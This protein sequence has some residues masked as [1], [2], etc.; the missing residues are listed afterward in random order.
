M[1]SFNSI[2]TPFNSLSIQSPRTLTG[3]H[4]SEISLINY[5]FYLNR[6]S[7]RFDLSLIDLLYVSNFKGGNATINV[8]ESELNIKLKSYSRLLRLIDEK[9]GKQSL[10]M[11]NQ[12]ETKSLVNLIMEMVSLTF[13]KETNIDGFKSSYL[14]ALLHSFFPML[15]P[16]LD[17]RLLINMG[18]VQ[19]S[20]LLSTKQV[21]KIEVFYPPLIYKMQE[22]FVNSTKTLRE[23][24]KE[25]FI[26]DLPNWAK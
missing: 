2:S 26:I 8:D 4:K 11:L 24:D 19:Q 12:V 6:K 16:I 23:L 21:R 13:L 17:R 25:Y 1:Q 22:V 7:D 15:I 18:L 20:D 14:S 9:F 10:K 3:W 5:Q